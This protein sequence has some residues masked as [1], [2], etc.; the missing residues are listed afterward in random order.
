ME[1]EKT[2]EVLNT[3]IIINNDR[4]EGYETAAKETNEYDLKNLFSQLAS[5]S[6]RF[7]QEL[8]SEVTKLGGQAEEGTKTTG[9]FFRVWMDVKAALTGKDRKAI[10]SS[11]EFGEDNAVETY[12]DVLRNNLSDITAVQQTL[13]NAQYALIKTDHDKVKNMRDSLQEHN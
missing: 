4:I 11:C 6:R 3:L 12:N 8:T 2:I 10:L 13:I 1:K 7:K 9:K 5:N